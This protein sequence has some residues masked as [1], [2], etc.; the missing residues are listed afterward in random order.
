MHAPAD[1]RL[2]EAIERARAHSPFLRQQL[3][4]LPEVAAALRSGSLEAALAAAAQDRDGDLAAAL[5]RER[6]GVAL[7]L[8]IGDLAGLLPLERVVE[9]LSDLADR[10]LD[11]A[12]AAAI[13]ERTPGAEPRGFA[14][15]A[16]GKH[17]SRELNFSSDIDLLFLYDPAALPL[18]P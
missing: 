13:A 3:E 14:I 9:T 2:A 8:A 6:S 5:R 18:K 17:G 16:L 4:T 10:A 11:R 7:A 1:L 12:V 15:I